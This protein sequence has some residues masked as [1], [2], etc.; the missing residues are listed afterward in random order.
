[1]TID[2]KIRDEKLQYDI[3]REVAKILALSY[4]KIDKYGYVTS[5][6]ILP[7]H[8]RK[9]IEQAKFTY[10]PLGNALEKQTKTIE[11]QSKKQIKATEGH[12][13]QFVESN[14][15]IKKDCNIDKG[16]IPL[17]EQKKNYWMNVL[18]KGLL[19]FGS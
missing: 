9:L 7:S 11:Y 17:E 2:D 16:S 8:Q 1:M 15:L 5:K 4:R 6:E 14:E 19:N 12:G 10:S 3:N 18:K 13:K